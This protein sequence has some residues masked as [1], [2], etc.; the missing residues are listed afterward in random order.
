MPEFFTA[1]PAGR[2]RA[3]HHPGPAGRALVLLPGLTC[4]AGYFDAIAPTLQDAYDVYA[5]DWRGHGGSA[6]APSYRFA[7]YVADLAAVVRAIA[8]SDLALV[9]HSLGGF[10]ALMYAADPTAPLAPHAVVAAD[11]KT[12]STPEEL[13]G[14]ARAAAKPQPVF[15][16]LDEL[17]ARLRAT[18]PDSRAA[19]ETLRRLAEAGAR[20]QADG[21]WS[22]AYDRAALAIEPVDPFAFAA[23]VQAPTLVL[24]GDRSPVMGAA[25]AARLAA[26]LPAGRAVAIADAGHH[27]FLD[28]PEAFIA[29][30]RPF[31]AASAAAVA[32]DQRSLA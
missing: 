17:A 18:M 1:G 20:R 21:G 12:G 32:E 5:L 27:P 4:H 29:A 31:L 6:P 26:A 7:D 19:D 2:L 3:I 16:S 23:A 11:V 14:A 9:G 28:Q 30:M 10:V 13:A 24:H 25:D 22:F 8:P 15:A